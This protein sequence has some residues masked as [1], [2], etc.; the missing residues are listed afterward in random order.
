MSFLAGV[1]A[2]GIADFFFKAALLR[3]NL[4][5][6]KFAHLKCAIQ[7]FLVY[8]QI[9]GA[10]NLTLE[11]FHHPRKKPVD[12]KCSLPI[13]PSPKSLATTDLLSP[14]IFAFSVHFI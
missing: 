3:C 9:C 6:I 1:L 11:H 10:H 12:I 5:T 4:H 2:S 13:S 7:W 8:L 14:Y